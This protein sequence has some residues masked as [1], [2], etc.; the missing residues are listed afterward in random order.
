MTT[1]PTI[2]Q[3]LESIGFNPPQQQKPAKNEPI[4]DDDLEE[5]EYE[6]RRRLFST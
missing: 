2:K 6:E 1:S 4:N 3:A 5:H